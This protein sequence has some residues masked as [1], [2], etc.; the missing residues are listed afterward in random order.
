MISWTTLA[1]VGIALAVFLVMEAVAWAAHKYIMH[2]WGW[3][4]HRSHHEPREGLFEKNDLYAV[5]FSVLAIALFAIAG[6]GHPV[7]GAIAVGITLYGAF[8]FIVHD[9]LVHQRW[10]FRNIPHK[11]YAKRLVQAHRLHHAVEGKDGAVSFGFLYAPPV[12]R[13]R[14]QLRAAGTIESERAARSRR[15]EDSGRD[16]ATLH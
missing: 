16:G 3:G 4:W 6:L 5:V 8:Y 12:D 14:D 11:G 7:V 10:P 9:G 1:L 13:L 2:G 15:P